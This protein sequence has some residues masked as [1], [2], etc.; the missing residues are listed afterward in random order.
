MP[1]AWVI[2]YTSRKCGHQTNLL[3]CGNSLL[4]EVI[5]DLNTELPF[6]VNFRQESAGCGRKLDLYRRNVHPQ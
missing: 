3:H 2:E 1:T 6:A 4:M 5:D